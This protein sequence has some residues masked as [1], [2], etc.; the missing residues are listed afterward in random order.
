MMSPYFWLLI[1]AVC[2]SLPLLYY[3]FDPI[4]LVQVWV[5]PNSDDRARILT[6]ETTTRSHG[7]EAILELQAELEDPTVN[8]VS[9]QIRPVETSTLFSQSCSVTNGLVRCVVQIGSKEWPINDDHEYAFQLL[10]TDDNSFLADGKILARVSKIAGGNRWI[11]MAIG[12]MASVTRLLELVV[13]SF[14]ARSH[15]RSAAIGNNK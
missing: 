5:I 3:A 9:L 2:V 15:E 4:S 14:A 10:K 11:V 1:V 13:R 7:A 12:V 8:A 6:K